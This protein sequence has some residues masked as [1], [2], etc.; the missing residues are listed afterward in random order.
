MWHEADSGALAY[1]G[2]F[3]VACVIASGLGLS[4]WADEYLLSQ[5]VAKK[6]LRGK[7]QMR[8]PL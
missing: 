7:N 2:V 8:S 4:G 3:E 5:Q 6:T 1:T